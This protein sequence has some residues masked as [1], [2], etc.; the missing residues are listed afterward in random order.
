[1]LKELLDLLVQNVDPWLR[2]YHCDY[3]IADA[4]DQI[5]NGRV[6]NWGD[7]FCTQVCDIFHLKKAVN[8]NLGKDNLKQNEKR[9]IKNDINGL[10]GCSE[11]GEFE[12]LKL[13]VLRK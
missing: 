9:N 10:I 11:E 4:G 12:T 3:F 5:W 2:F 1:M 8:S 13:L 7:E 6:V